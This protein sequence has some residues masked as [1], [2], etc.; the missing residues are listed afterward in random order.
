[1]KTNRAL[2]FAGYVSF[3]TLT[4]F[5]GAALIPACSG[6][7]ADTIEEP[8]GATATDAPV[9]TTP[10]ATTG[11]QDTGTPVGNPDTGST[12]IDTGTGATPDTGTT[13]PDTGTPVGTGDGG[14]CPP[15]TCTADS[16]CGCLT[17][18]GSI[19]CCDTV[20]TACFQ[21][22]SSVCP[23]QQTTTTPDSGGGGY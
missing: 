7:Q 23:D 8:D 19:G 15:A 1:M 16:D 11:A 10:D 6:N 12:F 13:A 17:A 2:G 3:T 4:L 9:S 5:G 18:S 21:S 20:T 14:A 22:A